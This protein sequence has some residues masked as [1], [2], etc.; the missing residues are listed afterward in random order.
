MADDLDGVVHAV[1]GNAPDGAH[2][3]LVRGGIHDVRR[4]LGPGELELLGN[5]VDRD[6]EV[7]PRE[8]GAGDHLQP[9]SAAPDDGD[10][11]CGLY[12]GDVTHR[13][14][15][16]DDAASE[17]SCMPQRQLLRD[18]YRAA[19][20]HDRVLCEA[21][22]SQ[23]VLERRPVREP[24]T[25]RPVHQHAPS[26]VLRDEL[27]QIRLAC[28]AV[29]ARATCGDEAERDTVAGLDVLTDLFDHACAFVSEDDRPVPVPE[30]AVRVAHIRVADP[31]GPDTHEDLACLRRVE[32]HL[33]HRYGLPGM[34]EHRG[35]HPHAARHRSGSSRSRLHVTG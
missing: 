24:E 4:S 30:L 27:A 18:R 11:F 5:A 9:D 22:G 7:R 28:D 17:E 35:L 6:D 2:R 23:T 8:A 31:G 25:A 16:G 34:S 19:H 21:R 13:A 33:L 15:P 32:I 29:A 26:A 12:A 3:I 1:A 14:H 20:H 10:R